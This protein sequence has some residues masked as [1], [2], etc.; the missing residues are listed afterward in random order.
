MD[1]AKNGQ[2]VIC[3]QCGQRGAV[4][5]IGNEPVCIQCEHMFQQSRY[6]QFA[7]NAAMMNYAAAELDAT[8]GFGPMSPQVVIP[9]APVPPIYYQNQSVTV[10]G[11]T[12]GSLNLGVARDIQVD[13]KTLTERGELEI[14]KSI[15]DLTNAILNAEDADEAAKNELIEQ[16]ALIS[17]QAAAK[18]EDRKP[19]QIKAV[20]A[21][22]KDGAEAISSVSGAWNA[23]APLITGYFGL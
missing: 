17:Q 19:G 23:I 8:L 10:S 14:S 3:G 20:M 18:P 2:R 15:A 4:F 16:L 22:I 7:Q 21:G 11:G 6:M 13:I 1:T 9:P 5:T 12:V